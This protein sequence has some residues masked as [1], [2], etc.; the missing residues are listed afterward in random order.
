MVKETSFISKWIFLNIYL[1]CSLLLVAVL[2][3]LP[4]QGAILQIYSQA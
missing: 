1:S 4:R 3:S 2:A